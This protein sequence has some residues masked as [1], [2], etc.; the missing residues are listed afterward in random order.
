MSKNRYREP[1]EHPENKFLKS[2]PGA[3]KFSKS[4]LKRIRGIQEMSDSGL[5]M[6]VLGLMKYLDD[7]RLSE[8]EIA[9]LPVQEVI[10]A[11]E[12]LTEDEVQRLTESFNP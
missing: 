5:D 10:R 1:Y 8:K 2:F 7:G 6:Y 12:A 3:G 9:S 11:G 4:L